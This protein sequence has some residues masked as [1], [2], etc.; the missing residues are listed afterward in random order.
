MMMGCW[1]DAER[2]L[3]DALSHDAKDA[4]SLAN[5]VTV[6]L[7]LGKNVSRYQSQLRMLAPRHPAVQRH[8]A[9]ED[10]FNRALAATS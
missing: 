1:E 10:L 9:A 2:D 4:D 8:E 5:L 3:L 6:Q 7:H